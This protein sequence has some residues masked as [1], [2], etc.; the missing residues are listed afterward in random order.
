M[1]RHFSDVQTTR[2]SIYLQQLCK[3]FG[4]KVPVKHDGKHGEINLPMGLCSLSADAH[5]LH[6]QTEAATQ[7]DANR[8][9]SVVGSHLERFAFRESPTIDWIET[10]QP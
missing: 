7:S 1:I 2:A 4:R 6:L 5:T 8:L 10:K 9:T 3:H